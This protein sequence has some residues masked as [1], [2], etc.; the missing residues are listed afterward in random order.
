MSRTTLGTLITYNPYAVG[1]A[2][3]LEEIAA[4]FGEL[5]IHHV[6]VVDG[7]RRVVGVISELDL[8]RARQSQPAVLV[9]A[10]KLDTDEA[11]VA[12]ARD[13]MTRD[14]LSISPHDDFAAALALLLK[15]RIHSLPVVDRGRLVGM[16]SSRDFLREF[17]YG[18]LPASR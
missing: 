10:G 12:F 14:V 5:H 4:R 8:L 15:R 9:T 11:P 18:E 3:L 6:P 17:S 13:V 1:P 16:V 7:E 2:T